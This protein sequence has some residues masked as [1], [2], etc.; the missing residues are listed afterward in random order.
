MTPAQREMLNEFFVRTFNSILA[1][2]ERALS[3]SGAKISVREL[4][5][6]EA[7]VRLEKQDCNTMSAVAGALHISVGALTTSVGTLIR[8]GYLLRGTDPSDRRIVKVLPTAAGLKVNAKHEAFHRD[9]LNQVE[10]V[11][12]EEDLARLTCALSKLTVFFD[13]YAVEERK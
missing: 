12:G 7:V 9:M 11:L 2:E 4:H 3:G 13:Q 6:V 10:M 8:K 1:F 5:V